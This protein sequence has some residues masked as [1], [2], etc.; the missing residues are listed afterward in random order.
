MNAITKVPQTTFAEAFVALQSSI[1]PAIKDAE[2]EAFKRG[3]KA[4]RYADLG[5]VWEAVKEPLRDNGFAVIQVPQFEGETMFL[6]TIL[7]H[8]SGEKMTGRYPLRPSKPDPQ[9]FG[10]A[11]TYARR[12]ALSAML[13]VVAD[14]DDDGNAASGVNGATNKIPTGKITVEQATTLRTLIER[15]KSDIEAFC[16]HFKVESIPDL[17]LAKFSTAVE[18]LNMKEQKK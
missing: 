5:A 2:N 17:P 14:D 18:L 3:G 10:S 8:I 6:E 11:I 4:S 12:Y 15:T 1:R 9:G 7:L 13:G 16:K